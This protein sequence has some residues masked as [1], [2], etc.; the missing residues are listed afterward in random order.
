MNNLRT[1]TLSLVALCCAATLNAQTTK[2]Y[3]TGS[4]AYRGAV[5]TAIQNIFDS[6]PTFAFSN[7]ATSVGGANQAI[8]TG[9]IGTNPYQISTS[10]SGSE[11][12]IQ[13]VAD[14]T[15]NVSFLPDST[16]PASCSASP[17]TSVASGSEAHHPDVAMA[18][19]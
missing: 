16:C 5:S 11:A 10:W 9:N 19:T 15:Q 18:D 6:P 1:I 13:T 7:N 14:A 2:V 17:G 4:T 3:I 8:F 12:G